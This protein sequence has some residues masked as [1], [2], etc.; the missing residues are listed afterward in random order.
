M[1]VDLTQITGLIGTIG[2]VIKLAGS[3]KNMEMVNAA[4]ELQQK[5][6]DVQMAMSNLIDENHTLK[7]QVRELETRAKLESELRFEQNVYWRYRDGA[8][9][10]ETTPYC[11]RCWDYEKKL[12]HLNRGDSQFM[13]VCEQDGK[14]YKSMERY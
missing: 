9:K 11:P 7:Q 6:N 4:L 8:E 5:V 2:T 1:D 10:P 12:V 14:W 3:A 13:Y